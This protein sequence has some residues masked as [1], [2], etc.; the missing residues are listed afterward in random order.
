LHYYTLYG[1][2]EVGFWPEDQWDYS[3]EADWL[4]SGDTGP[5]T[6]CIRY[7]KIIRGEEL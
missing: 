5:E 3:P 7:D 4:Y 6:F 1:V 2:I